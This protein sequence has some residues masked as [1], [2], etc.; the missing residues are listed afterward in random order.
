M[1]QRVVHLVVRRGRLYVHRTMEWLLLALAGLGVWAGHESTS[2]L[3]ALLAWAFAAACF[4]YACKLEG[5]WLKAHRLPIFGSRGLPVHELTRVQRKTGRITPDFVGAEWR[6]LWDLWY[7]HRWHRTSRWLSRPGNI[8]LGL[9]SPEQRLFGVIGPRQLGFTPPRHVVLLA[10]TRAGKGTMGLVPNLLTLPNSALVVDP[11]GEL[12]RITAARRGG[13][14]AQF[15]KSRVTESMGQEVHVF[16]PFDTTQ[17]MQNATFNPLDEL[18]EN[19]PAVVTLAGAIARAL[20]L[21]DATGADVTFQDRARELIQAV[22]LHVI[23]V[24]DPSRR[25]LPHVWNFLVSGDVEYLQYLQHEAQQQNVTLS[26]T[27]PI[28]AL[29]ACMSANTAFNGLVAGAGSE[30]L[31]LVPETRDGIL[32][33]ARRE[34]GFLKDPQMQRAIS[35]STF[36]LRDIFDKRMTIYLCLPVMKVVGEQRRIMSMFLTLLMDLLESVHEPAEHPYL[37]I[38]EFP[39]LGHFEPLEKA[40]GLVK[41]RFTVWAVFQDIGQMKKL[42]K[43]AW[44]TFISN[45]SIIALRVANPETANWLS[46]LLGQ[47]IGPSGT[48]PLIAPH[49]LLGRFSDD[50]DRRILFLEGV[51]AILQGTPYMEM[52]PTTLYDHVV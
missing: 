7:R 44:E 39:A 15:P 46:N 21:G 14:Q 12:A 33:Y 32:F 8:R 18:D 5:R 23:T 19:D 17:G 1:I 4:I 22:I 11:K 6:S 48:V 29:F 25:S 41:Y 43:E 42:Y 24:E 49:E 45:S 40:M 36:R 35:S 52:F 26:I 9:S 34:L 38:D 3:A 27:T 31:Q 28:E 30:M 50:E 51:P 16:D 37:I 2:A 13:G 20:V 47:V 10:P